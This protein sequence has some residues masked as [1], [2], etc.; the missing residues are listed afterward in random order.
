MGD[1][2]YAACH[3]RKEILRHTGALA[4]STTAASDASTSTTTASATEQGAPSEYESV[5]YQ[6]LPQPKDC[7]ADKD[8][9]RSFE[10]MKTIV[11]S[12]RIIRDRA[13]IPVKYPLKELVVI[14][15]SQEVGPCDVGVGL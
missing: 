7:Y 3:E 13:T 1:A 9:V 2:R 10:V 4:A 5:H 12:G 14:S 8:I 11:N 15:K 6:M